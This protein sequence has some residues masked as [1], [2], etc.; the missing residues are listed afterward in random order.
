MELIVQ[1]TYELLRA[2]LASYLSFSSQ[3]LEYRRYLINESKGNW[4]YHSIKIELTTPKMHMHAIMFMYVHWAMTNQ[5]CFIHLESSGL[6]EM[7]T[8]FVSACTCVFTWK[9]KACIFLLRETSLHFLSYRLTLAFLHFFFPINEIHHHPLSVCR[10][11]CR[12]PLPIILHQILFIYPL[13]V[14]IYAHFRPSRPP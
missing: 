2:E 13:R 3:W 6:L 7:K 14:F 4:N 12:L 9:W 8:V 5:S 1:P 10:Q 11:K